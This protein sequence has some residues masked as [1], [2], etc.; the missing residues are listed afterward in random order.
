MFKG[1]Y[2]DRAVLAIGVTRIGANFHAY[3][4]LADTLNG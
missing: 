4:Q 3:F 2:L 1:R